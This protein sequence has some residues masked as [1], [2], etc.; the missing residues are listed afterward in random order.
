MVA[1]QSNTRNFKLAMR[2]YGFRSRKQYSKLIYAVR[3][4]FNR[5]VDKFARRR[6]LQVVWL[7]YGCRVSGESLRTRGAYCCRKLFCSTCILPD[8][9]VAIL[10]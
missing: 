8:C 6:R 7:A 10:I 3:T 2:V 1:S 4:T 9:V 5:L